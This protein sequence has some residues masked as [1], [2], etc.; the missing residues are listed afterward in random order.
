MIKFETLEELKV[1]YPI[2]TKI[3][4]RSCQKT[5]IRYYSSSADLEIFKKLY[6]N[7]EILNNAQCRVWY[8]E[9]AYDEVE[10][11]LFDGEYWYPVKNS[12]DGWI[13]I[14]EYSNV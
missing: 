7:I 2:G 10:G 5:D 3:N 1:K 12:Y 4:Y 6:N 14:E 9:E 13:E 11:Y 8:T